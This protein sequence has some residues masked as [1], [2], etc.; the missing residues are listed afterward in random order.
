M[1][2][3]LGEYD[4]F[5]DDE[6][7]YQDIFVKTIETHESY[8]PSTKQNDIALVKLE[9]SVEYNQYVRPLC[10]PNIDVKPNETIFVAGSYETFMFPSRKIRN[11]WVLNFR[12]L[13]HLLRWSSSIIWCV[14]LLQVWSD[15]VITSDVI[16]DQVPQVENVNFE[17][18]TAFDNEKFGK[19]FAKT[20]SIN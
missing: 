18:I 10:L 12:Y 13:R 9:R 2:I 6:T 1:V 8:D 14:S 19:H 7:K 17:L 4:L 5:E 3:R 15:L 11:S 16:Y 20:I